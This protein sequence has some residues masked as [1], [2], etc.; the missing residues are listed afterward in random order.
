VHINSVGHARLSDG[1]LDTTAIEDAWYCVANHDCEPKCPD[2]A[3]PIVIRGTINA[4]FLL[5]L[6]GGLDGT[7]AT[8]E[9]VDV[10]SAD[11]SDEECDP[12]EP[13]EDEFCKRYR[14]YV[15][16]AESQDSDIS[17]GQA[18]EIARRFEDMW[19]VAPPELKEWVELV[20][21][22]YA[23]FAGIEEP[24]NIPVTGHV[25]GIQYLPDALQTMHAYCGIPW[26]GSGE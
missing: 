13:A 25:L 3:L 16:W 19:P 11:E 5:A 1:I 7:T 15:A 4:R 22:I 18:A 10:I 14:D 23:T 20:F 21:T 8:I 12:E 26:F 2:D 6:A 9:G 17:Q 24:Y